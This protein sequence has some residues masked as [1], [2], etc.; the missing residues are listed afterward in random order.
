MMNQSLLIVAITIVGLFYFENATFGQMFGTR[1][2]GNPL[3]RQIGPGAKRTTSPTDPTGASA[4]IVQGSERFVRGSRTGNQFVGADAGDVSN[5]V[6][7]VNAGHQTADVPPAIA[8]PARRNLAPMIN[9]PIQKRPANSLLEPQLQIAFATGPETTAGR[10]EKAVTA[11]ETVLSSHFGNLISV[12][13]ADQTAT[14]RGVVPDAE[15][16][17][18]AELITLMEPGISQVENQLQAGSR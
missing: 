5:F 1:T 16:V 12:S 8:A 3:S 9:R 17:R 7:Q 15:S 11:I 10:V 6:G 18:L 14:L 4:G 2:V 13:V